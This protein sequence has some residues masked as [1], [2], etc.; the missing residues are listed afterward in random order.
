MHSIIVFLSSIR[1]ML[2]FLIFFN[3]KIMPISFIDLAKTST[4][5]FHYNVQT[6]WSQLAE[7]L[8][9]GIGPYYYKQ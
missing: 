1:A 5:T 6:D 2:F 3:V 8:V 4:N 9:Q 7:N